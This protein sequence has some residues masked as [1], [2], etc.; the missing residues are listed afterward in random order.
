MS[1]INN[2]LFETVYTDPSGQDWKVLLHSKQAMNT[3]I[4]VGSGVAPT[5]TAGWAVTWTWSNLNEPEFGDPNP[6]TTYTQL[7][8]SGLPFKS[9]SS[10]DAYVVANVAGNTAIDQ[11]S[12]QI[13]SYTADSYNYNMDMAFPGF[14]IRW[15][16]QADDPNKSI[17]GS[18]VDMT[19]VVDDKQEAILTE[20]LMLGEYNLTLSIFK[21]DAVGDFHA[22]W[23]GVA[24][25]E[26][27][28]MQVKDHKR[29]FDLSFS[30]GLALL[31]D[32]DWKDPSTGLPLTGQLNFS[33]TIETILKRLPHFDR[34]VLTP[35]VGGAY[36]LKEYGT[37]LPVNETRDWDSSLGSP[38]EHMYCQAE[39][40]NE[41][42]VE[43]DRKF[44]MRPDPGFISTG[45][46]LEDICKTL[47]MVITQWEGGWHLFSPTYLAQ[48]TAL[49][50]STNDTTLAPIALQ[51]QYTDAAGM[52]FRSSR[53]VDIDEELEDYAAPQAGMTKSF[54]LPFR[55]VKMSHERS[56]SD[57]LY[58]TWNSNEPGAPAWSSDSFHKVAPQHAGSPVDASSSDLLKFGDFRLGYKGNTPQKRVKRQG[59]AWTLEHAYYVDGYSFDA[60]GGPQG[61]DLSARGQHKRVE[62]G[63]T[64][65]GP[66][67]TFFDGRYLGPDS[68]EITNVD[69]E[70]GETLSIEMGGYVENGRL[71][72]HIGNTYVFHHRIEVESDSGTKYRLRRH[73]ITQDRWVESGTERLTTIDGSNSDVDK[74]WA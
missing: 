25:P 50:Q 57:V 49:F 19:L 67:P 33:E 20:A 23:H 74:T 59:T 69:L 9:Y 3:G 65:G 24:L 18:G 13:V 73:V 2:T 6:G 41:D 51:H 22:W 70:A 31:N 63:V 47:G 35:T 44:E 37:P 56:S 32:L 61:S 1:L 64:G 38:L 29:L 30:C 39:T 45:H 11:T 54:L 53:Q 55:T 21:G 27:C 26:S 68:A 17:L 52:T 36:M 16:G 34:F 8:G 66:N 62:D 40:F 4:Q 58:G 48:A 43:Y 46:V 72:E 60:N 14:R 28:S 7:A 5:T 42:K 10:A 12:V 71:D 15:E